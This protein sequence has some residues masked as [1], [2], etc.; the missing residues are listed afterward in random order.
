MKINQIKNL[1]LLTAFFSFIGFASANATN[2]AIL[3]IENIVKNSL[4]MKD[5]QGKISKK[6]T[7]FQKEID[8]KQSQLEAENKKLESKKSILAEDAY[9]KEQ[10]TFDKKVGELR[11]HLEKRQNSLKKASAE[12]LSKVNEKIKEIIVELSKEKKF[13]IVIPSSQTL[14]YDETIDISSEVLKRL[15]KKITKVDVKFN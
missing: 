9:A 14:Y 7:E 6:Q 5:I 10:A 11:D 12:S 2:V 13:D 1:V 3:D 15:N 8:K 4:V